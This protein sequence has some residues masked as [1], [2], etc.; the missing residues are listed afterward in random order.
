MT[1]PIVHCLDCNEPMNEYPEYRDELGLHTVCKH[2]DSSFDIPDDG[3]KEYL[4]YTVEEILK[5]MEHLNV[6]NVIYNGYYSGTGDEDYLHKHTIATEHLY[7]RAIAR[8]YGG[9]IGPDDVFNG[10]CFDQDGTPLAEWYIDGAEEYL[11]IH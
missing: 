4:T 5:D 1:Q 3:E 6:L 8:S 9:E 7:N 2:C 11:P 10:V